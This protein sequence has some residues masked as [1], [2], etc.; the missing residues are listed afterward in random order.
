MR[1]NVSSFKLNK[2]SLKAYQNSRAESDWSPSFFP[3]SPKTAY[4]VSAIKIV[5]FCINGKVIIFRFIFFFYYYFI[6][7]FGAFFIR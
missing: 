1:T 4:T 7:T 2:M 3:P 5:R 6:K